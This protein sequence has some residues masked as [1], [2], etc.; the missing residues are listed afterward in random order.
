M[1]NLQTLAEQAKGKQLDLLDKIWLKVKPEDKEDKI[2]A[3]VV[4]LTQNSLYSIASTLVLL[5]VD[6][7]WELYFQ[8]SDG[9]SAGQLKRMHIARQSSI[10]DWVMRNGKPMIVNNPE[11]NSG[12]HK[13]LDDATGFRTRHAI[14]APLISG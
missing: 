4:N 11:K 14:A 3:N 8:T 7:K 10:A 9:P 1:P 13:L 5:D 6:N 2:I 12:F